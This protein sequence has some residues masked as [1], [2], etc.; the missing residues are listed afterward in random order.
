MATALPLYTAPFWYGTGSESSGAT[1]CT[2]GLPAG[3][4]VEQNDFLV[5]LVNVG[6]TGVATVTPGGDET[7][8]EAPNSPLTMSGTSAATHPHKLYVFVCRATAG[9]AAPTVTRS[10]AGD[11]VVAQ[12]V[13]IRGVATEGTAASAILDTETHVVTGTDTASTLTFLDTA[14]TIK[15]TCYIMLA[16]TGSD[17]ASATHGAITNASVSFLTER[18]DGGTATGGGGT[19]YC[20]VGAEFYTGAFAAGAPTC[21]PFTGGQQYARFA[22]SL[23]PPQLRLEP[24]VIAT[25]EQIY[26]PT[27]SVDFLTVRPPR[28]ESAEVVYG[29]TLAV[30]LYTVRPPRI[31]SGEVV[32]GGDVQTPPDTND[33]TITVLE[34][35]P[36]DGVRA[37]SIIR[38]QVDDD[39]GIGALVIIAEILDEDGEVV[40]EDVVYDGLSFGFRYRSTT[41]TAEGEEG[42]PQYLLNIRRDGG[43]TGSPRFRYVVR[44]T[45]G[46]SA[47]VP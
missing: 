12:M 7:W 34:P 41:N 44:D 42:D 30:D 1:T 35:A 8:E 20:A 18:F 23:M 39:N 36:E 24:D 38:L 13:G 6:S 26:A 14:P 3:T 29:G 40:D 2:P 47:V 32:F 16:T 31:E 11:Y 15:N 9:I 5:M 45:A 21:S 19:T 17:A 4:T 10:V 46:R 37:E 28:I 27:L 22:L 43:W 25:A 33:P